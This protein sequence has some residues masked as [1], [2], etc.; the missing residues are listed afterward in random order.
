MN[1]DAIVLAGSPNEGDLK[2]CS[3]ATEEALIKIGNKYMV[4]YVV[5][6]LKSSS[7]V[8]KIVVVG[9]KEQLAPIFGQDILVAEGGDTAID[10]LLKGL[11]ELNSTSPV[12]V[13][14]SDIP[15]L[16]S[17]AIEDFLNCCSERDADFYYPIIE[18]QVVEARFPKAT[19]TYVSLLEGVFTG[20]N[21]MLVKPQVAEKCASFARLVIQL[22]K[23]PVKLCQLLGA[24]IL[25][26]YLI[27]KLSINEIEERFSDLLQ[28]SGAAVISKYPEIGVDVDKPVD[29]E[30]VLSNLGETA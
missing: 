5:E 16:T 6:A 27:K 2:E 3:S 22:R 30:L 21:I 1:C 11:A 8:N 18:Q 13:V 26:K 23:R 14:C 24:K 15:L 4:E 9:V 29:L 20:G 25:F 12:L 10:T 28:I 7:K 19:R 17:A